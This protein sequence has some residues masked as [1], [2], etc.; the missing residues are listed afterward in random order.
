M[1]SY[2]D[3]L[4]RL[5]FS[6]E[7][8]AE[9]TRRLTAERTTATARRRGLPYRG[10][11]AAVA[12]ISLLVGAVGAVSLAGVSPA[13]RELFGITDDAQAQQLGAERLNLVFE[14]QNGSGA[15]I[16]V[17]EVVKDRERVYVLLDFTAPAGVTLPTPEETADGRNFWL[18]EEE[19]DCSAAFYG[20]EACTMRV[21]PRSWGWGFRAVN[22]PDTADQVIPLML[23]ITCDETLPEEATWL[24][25]THLSNLWVLENGKETRVLSGMDFTLAIP[26]ET[27][28]EIYSFEGRCGVNLNGVTLATAENLTISPVSVAMD[29]VIPDG[30]AYDAAFEA[31]GPWQMYVLLEDGTQV[32][33]KFEKGGG[34]QDVFHDDAGQTFFR[35]DHV[36]F[37]L[38]SPIDVAQIKDIVFIGDNSL[39]YGEKENDGVIHFSFTP[40]F[41]RNETYWNQ[42][43]EEWKNS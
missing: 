41:F 35:A 39:V 8:K 33:T 9:L 37:E 3:E 4:D 42:V 36:R 11:V 21:D 27:T 14:D 38:E 10:L 12:A 29:L 17:K 30:T 18:G 15:S 40:H 6:P 22:D 13:F 32:W 26:I 28:A 2:Q 16:A 5:K 23:Q 43:N 25:V 31:Q 1:A 20:D 7:E 24:R 19:G 34:V